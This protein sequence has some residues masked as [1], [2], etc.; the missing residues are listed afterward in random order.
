MVE[1]TID[2]SVIVASLLEQEKHHL[3]ALNLWKEVVAG[4]AIAIM[5]YTVLVEVVA[6]IRRRTGQK[7][8]A[9]QVKKEL[10]SV[11]AVHF[12]IVEP[13]SASEASDIA[14]ETGVRGMDAVVIQTAKEYNTALVSLDSEMMEKSSAIVKIRTL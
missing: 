14:I 6:A 8:L 2:S 9:Q 5:P 3:R 12:V 13:D 11:E 4:N 1:L 7:E 10:L